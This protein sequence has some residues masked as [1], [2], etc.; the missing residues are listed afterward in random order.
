MNH[1]HQQKDL[2][3]DRYKIEN[4]L[5]EGGMQEVYKAYDQKLERLVVVK[6]PKN[7]SAHKRF[8]RSA[9]VSAK[10]NHP[11]VAKT[12]D[13]SE[14]NKSYLIEEFI[15]GSDLGIRLEKEFNFFDPHLSAHVTHHLVKAIAIAHRA[16]IFHRDLKPSNIMVSNDPNLSHIK[17]T[18]FGIAKMTEE[19]F[20]S[21]LQQVESSITTSKTIVGAIPFMSPELVQ[22]PKNATKS[23]DIWSIGAILYYLMTGKYPFGSGLT[24][25]IGISAAKLPEKPPLFEKTQF[26]GLCN[27]LWKIIE[28]CLQ[29]E[30]GS[31][32]TADELV[33]EFS[34]VCY[35][36]SERQTG[37]IKNFIGNNESRGFISCKDSNDVFFHVDSFYSSETPTIGMKVNFAKFDGEPKPRAF[38]LLP[39]K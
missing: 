26:K 13:F 28:R 12:L 11:N 14:D 9:Q 23:S 8:K 4:Y 16:D 34:K 20:N 33:G 2:I 29:K 3:M 24:A 38:P 19:K 15:E 31:R 17:L 5:A 25:V 27:Q 37:Q 35:S 21:E 10:I 1:I 30:P 22:T 39:I 36:L 6:T 18:D 7:E 32:P